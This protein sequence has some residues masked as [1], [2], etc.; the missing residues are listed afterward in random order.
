MSISTSIPGTGSSERLP[1][2]RSV[3]A[4]L[5]AVRVAAAFL[6][7]SGAAWKTPPDFGQDSGGGL[8]R[9]VHFAVEYP[10]LPPYTWVVEHVVLTNFP[11]FGWLVLLTEAALGA[12]LLVGL[13]VRLVAGVAVLQTFA[14]MAATLNAPHEW[15]WSYYLMIAVHLLLIAFAAGR[16]YGLDGILRPI[17][18]NSSR[19]GTRLLL[20]AS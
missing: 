19:A 9:W 3:A 11:I 1:E 17:W 12:F 6:W 20:S 15:P 13:L 7:M 4:T 18:R 2:G 10:V 16:V 14:I 8:Y 5:A